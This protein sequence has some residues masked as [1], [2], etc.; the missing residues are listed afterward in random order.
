MGFLIPKMYHLNKTG[1]NR[2]EVQLLAKVELL[3]PKILR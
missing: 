3:H 2:Q 1:L